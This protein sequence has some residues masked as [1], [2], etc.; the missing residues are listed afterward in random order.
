M[1]PHLRPGACGAA[2]RGDGFLVQEVD[3]GA[4]A[5]ADR[6]AKLAVVEHRVPAAIRKQLKEH[7][8][9]VTAK[10][11]CIARASAIANDQPGK[12][13]RDTEASRAKAAQA[14]AARLKLKLAQRHG[15]TKQR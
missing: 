7:D 3:V 14:A 6:Y 15:D 8:E 13:N 12:P 4:N 1:P 11:K 5:E 10:A 2:V 9:L